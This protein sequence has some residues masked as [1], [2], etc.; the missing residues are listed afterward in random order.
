M[1]KGYDIDLRRAMFHRSTG[2]RCFA[3]APPMTAILLAGLLLA[4]DDPRPTQAEVRAC[5]ERLHLP[6][7]DPK[8]GPSGAD[9]KRLRDCVEDQRR[10]NKGL[11]R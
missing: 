4:A 7:P 10:N 8:T 5:I 11:A 2:G 1:G 3:I 9:K 6:R